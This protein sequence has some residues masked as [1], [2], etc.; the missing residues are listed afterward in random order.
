MKIKAPVILNIAI[1]F[2]DAYIRSILS[3][4]CICLIIKILTRKFGFERET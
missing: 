1:L 3:N 2:K 4:G